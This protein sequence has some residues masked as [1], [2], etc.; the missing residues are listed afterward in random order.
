MKKILTIICLTWALA[1]CSTSHKVSSGTVHPD[2]VFTITEEDIARETWQINSALSGE[3]KYNGPS[4]GVSG[5]NLLAGVAKP[6][7]KSKLKKKLKN[8]FKKIG[9]DKAR[10]A[11]SFNPDGTCTMN[12]LGANINGSYNYNPF[13]EKI[14]FKWHGVP[15]TASLR[16]DG[17]KKLHLTFDADKLLSLI[18]LVGRFSDNTAIK[19]LR[20]LLDNY[21]DVMV[22]FELKK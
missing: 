19:A 3:W 8:A 4:V 9:L 17:K 18:S 20:T 15:L 11:F 7:A 6:L 21:E 14:T 12:L 10:P 1:S 22:G 16:K 13:Q 2:E 5:R